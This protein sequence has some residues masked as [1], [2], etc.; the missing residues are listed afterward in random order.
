MLTVS[1]RPAVTVLHKLVSAGMLST[2]VWT[3]GIPSEATKAEG[4]LQTSDVQTTGILLHQ[5]SCTLRAIGDCNRPRR[6][7]AHTLV[8]TSLA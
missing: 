3:P 2:V 5:C 4:L 7:Q 8:A 6:P 1:A